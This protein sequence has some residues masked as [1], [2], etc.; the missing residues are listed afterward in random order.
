M[1]LQTSF[2]RIFIKFFV[3]DLFQLIVIV[4]AATYEL[5]HNVYSCVTY[6]YTTLRNLLNIQS[7]QLK[8]GRRQV[9]KR[10]DIGFY[11]V[12][13]EQEYRDGR[14]FKNQ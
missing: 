9:W 13:Q 14:H 3:D 5:K 6:R 12:R 1:A 8:R 4:F 10:F 11:C 2:S 7:N